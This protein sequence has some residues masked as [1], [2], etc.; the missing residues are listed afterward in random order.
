MAEYLK[1]CITHSEYLEFKEG[2][3]FDIPNVSYCEADDEVH[4]NPWVET[5]LVAKFN[6]T[7]TSNQ[8][9]IMGSSAAS[10]FSK[11]WIDGVEQPSVVSSC[12]FSTTGEH[13][14]KYTL[15]DPTSIG[16]DAFSGCWGLTSITIPS[17]VTS[18]GFEAFFDCIYMTSVT[19]PNGVTSIGQYAFQYCTS[20]DTI[21]SLATTAPRISSD[22]FQNVKTGGTLIVPQGSTGY[23]SWMGTG[24]Y[25]L[26]SYGWTKVEQ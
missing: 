17:G 2:A 3:D 15:V 13:T 12:T 14:V 5:R 11:I 10:L 26:G 4:Y 6:V 25:Y 7:S 20:L 24:S 9:K 19:I 22:T 18:I 1:Y 21:T 16:A 23:N 8:T